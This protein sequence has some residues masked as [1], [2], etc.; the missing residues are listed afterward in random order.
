MTAKEMFEELGYEYKDKE[1]I[2]IIEIIKG[3]FYLRIDDDKRK[4]VIKEYDKN[5][6][7]EVS[8]ELLQAINKQVE[9]LHWNE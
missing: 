9:E 8:Q 6:L 5:S 4:I 1:L 7:C 2:N 3:T